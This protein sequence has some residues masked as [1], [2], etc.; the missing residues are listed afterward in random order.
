M[1][2][3]GFL[4]ERSMPQERKMSAVFKIGQLD[5]ACQ[6]PQQ[7][8][9]LGQRDFVACGT[10]SPILVLI[11]VKKRGNAWKRSR[12]AR[13][14][15]EP[16]LPLSSITWPVR[17]AP[18]APLQVSITKPKRRASIPAFAAGRSCSIQRQNLNR[19]LVGRALPS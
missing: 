19:A 16:N 7:L 17:R 15:G 11:M 2:N 1:D 6:L 12:R 3:A 10:F 18:S 5:A 13:L 4:P 8:N 9:R 14:N